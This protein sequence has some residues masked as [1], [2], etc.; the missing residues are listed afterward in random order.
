[1]HACFRVLLCACAALCVIGVYCIICVPFVCLLCARVF[2]C[3][4]ACAFLTVCLVC[5]FSC[6]Y[7]V[8]CVCARACARV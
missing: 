3:V 4:R 7:R 6:A 5:A 2:G 8:H 1:M